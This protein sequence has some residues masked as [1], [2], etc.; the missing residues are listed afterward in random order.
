M[1]D[2]RPTLAYFDPRKKTILTV[3][4]SPTGLGGILTQEDSHEEL[5]IVA[6]ASKALSDVEK[7]YSHTEREALAVIWANITISICMDN[8]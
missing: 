4:A 8:Q 7:R 3:D 5:P 6:Y 1:L 2:T